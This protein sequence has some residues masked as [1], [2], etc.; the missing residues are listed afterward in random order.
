MKRRALLGAAGAATLVDALGVSRAFAQSADVPRRAMPAA[1]GVARVGVLFVNDAPTE[2]R[3]DPFIAAF[4]RGLRERGYVEGENIL[5]DVRY[6]DGRPERLAAQAAEL[7][8]L[9]VDVILTGGQPAREA[10][11]R[12]TGT[13]PIVQVS[14]SDAVREGWARSL[15]RPGGNLTGLT[16]TYPELMPKSLELL[17]EALPGIVRVAVLIDPAQVID[18]RE[19]LKETEAGAGRLG[20]RLQVPDIRGPGDFVAAFAAAQQQGAQAVF[21]IGMSPFSSQ[22]AALAIRNRLPS[23]GDFPLMAQAGFLLS[24]GADLVDLIRRAA[25]YVDKILKGGRPGDLAIER[26]T[27]FQLSVNLV[28]AKALGLT[29]PRS[30]LLRADEVIQ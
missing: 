17:N 8:A 14:G 5:L 3:P 24:Y 1:A 13:V 30:L 15:A 26:P 19:V 22:L 4:R 27:T 16:V 21:A 2:T 9:K 20:M 25:F 6:M 12:A 23:V 28:T 7:V 10:V 11:R 18:A 29:M